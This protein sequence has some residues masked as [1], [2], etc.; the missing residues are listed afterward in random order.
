M[1]TLSS[2]PPPQTP[3]SRIRTIE[4]DATCEL[5]NAYYRLDRKNLRS[6][7]GATGDML[8]F[9]KARLESLIETD[10]FSI[11]AAATIKKYLPLRPTLP[12]CVLAELCGFRP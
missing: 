8:A 5:L 11:N 3:P 9:N 2:R 7:A 12:L 10:S 4:Y 6:S 1:I